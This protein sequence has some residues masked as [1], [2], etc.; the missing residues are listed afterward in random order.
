[1][2][3]WQLAMVHNRLLRY[4]KV[5]NVGA[6]RIARLELEEYNDLTLEEVFRKAGMDKEPA[7]T[8]AQ[9]ILEGDPPNWME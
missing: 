6:S 1:M 5:G 3:D 9:Y 4:S 7:H 8:F 2:N